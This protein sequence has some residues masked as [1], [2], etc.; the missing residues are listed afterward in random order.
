MSPA[1]D[2][3][4]ALA[5][6]WGLVRSDGGLSCA[7]CELRDATLPTLCCEDCIAKRRTSLRKCGLSQQAPHISKTTR[8]VARLG[9]G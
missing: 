6:R 8:N 3:G 9:T 1:L 7:C 4:R 5:H 2:G